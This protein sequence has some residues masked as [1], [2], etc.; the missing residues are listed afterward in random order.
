MYHFQSYLSNQCWALNCLKTILYTLTY[1]DGK[2]IEIPGEKNRGLNPG[3]SE[4]S[5]PLS[6]WSPGAEEQ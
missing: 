3:P 6:Y 1:L 4:Y 2:D 5:Y